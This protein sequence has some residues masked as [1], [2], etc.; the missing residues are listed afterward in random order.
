MVKAWEQG[1]IG[2]PSNTLHGK[3]IKWGST[4]NASLETGGYLAHGCG[5]HVKPKNNVEA[6]T[7]GRI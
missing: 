2:L 3:F 1:Y 4:V 6:I 5:C 7:Q